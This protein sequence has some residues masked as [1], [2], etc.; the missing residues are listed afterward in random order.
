[1]LQPLSI[2]GLCKNYQSGH[3]SRSVHI[4]AL[5]QN[6][7]LVVIYKKKTLTICSILMDQRTKCVSVGTQRVYTCT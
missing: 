4:I 3:F 1:M 7:L 2:P 5:W 6:V